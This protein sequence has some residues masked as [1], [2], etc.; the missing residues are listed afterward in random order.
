MIHPNEVRLIDEIL[1]MLDS[2]EKWTQNQLARDRDNNPVHSSDPEATCW[3]LCGA[4]CQVLRTHDLDPL[5][6]EYMR[7]TNAMARHVHNNI[8]PESPNCYVLFNDD[9]ETTYDRRYQPTT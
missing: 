9:P 1:T 2:P 6:T 8:D 5:A 4:I 7:I 3:C